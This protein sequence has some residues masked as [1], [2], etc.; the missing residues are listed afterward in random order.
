VLKVLAIV[1]SCLVGLAWIV[2]VVYAL[3][4]GAR[5]E[6]GWSMT[7]VAVGVLTIEA[8]LAVGVIW[9]VLLAIERIVRLRRE[10][11]RPEP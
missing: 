3:Q 6:P 1:L 7:P 2:L 9:G 5:L 10:L 8:A 11:R 4:S